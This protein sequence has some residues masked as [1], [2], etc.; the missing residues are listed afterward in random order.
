MDLLLLQ[1]FAF[2]RPIMFLDLGVQIGGLNVFEVAALLLTGALLGGMLIR[3]AVRKDLALS[4]ADLL[5]I[6]FAIWCIVIYFVY[7]DRADVKELAKFVLPFL[8]YVVA[9]NILVE[10]GA[11]RTLILIM[12]LGFVP[13]LVV[14]TVMTLLGKGAEWVNFW[15][16]SARY[17]GLYSGPHNMAHNMTF[18]LMLIGLYVALSRT[19]GAKRLSRRTLVLLSTM[20]LAALYCLYFS[21]VRTAIIGLAVF[22]AMV[23]LFVNRRALLWGVAVLVLIG[24]GFS[25]QLRDRLYYESVAMERDTTATSDEIVASGRPYIWRKNMEEFLAMP[26]DR[27]L[28]GVGIGNSKRRP[29]SDLK[30]IGDSH[31]DVLEVLIQ[32]GIVGFLLFL[33]LNLALFLAVLRLQGIERYAF[34]G[35]FLAVMFMNLASNSYVSRFGLAQMYYV[36]FAYVELRR[37]RVTAE[38]IRLDRSLSPA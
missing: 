24:I 13:P 15:T 4:G 37:S 16:G 30:Q 23:L 26:I 31:N 28:A 5:M 22:A 27:Q 34:L 2:L 12:I 9:K 38:D 14:T 35:L 25:Q 7:I 11:Y 33:G 17:Q 6:G 3:A 8:G 10:R 32:T 1:L 21:G 36:V 18:L 19:D 20:A 29:G